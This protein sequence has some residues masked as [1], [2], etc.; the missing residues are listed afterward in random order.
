MATARIA[1]YMP[2]VGEDVVAGI[3]ARMRRLYG[4][5]LTHVNSTYTGGGVAEMLTS[6]VS[7]TND[8]GVDADWRI[9]RGAP[10]FFSITKRMHNG[11]QGEAVE[12]SDLEKAIY[13]GTNEAFAG[14]ARLE[15]DCVVVHDP[16][17]LPMAAFFRRRQPWVW[18]CHIDLSAP[19]DSLWQLIKPHIFRYD[20]VI[21]SSSSYLHPDMTVDHRIIAPAIDPLATKN[22]EMSQEDRLSVLADAGVPTDRPL[23]TQVS[24]FDKWKDPQG[25]IDVYKLVREE[26]DCRLVLCGSGAA[27]DPEGHDI[28]AEVR[29]AA[30]ELI[31]NGDVVIFTD[32]DNRFVNALQSASSVIV[33]KSLREGFG[34]TVTEG[35]WKAKPVVASRVGGIP[36][37]IEDGETGFL[38]EPND[39]EGFARRI[40]E[41]L[42]DPDSAHALGTA[43]RETVRQRFLITRLVSDYLDLLNDIL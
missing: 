8:L 20:V 31:E 41:V 11:L 39:T 24:R 19:A 32:L 2:I 28:L 17:P 26:V 35:L 12:L 33:Q 13:L 40:V 29:A 22:M 21:L 37:Q 36:L 5:R 23:I 42:K 4:R 9:L 7:L 30:G 10:E 3:R 1:D 15:D 43:G 18:R 6:L 38:V 14:Y 16:Q 25:V 34:L 27:D